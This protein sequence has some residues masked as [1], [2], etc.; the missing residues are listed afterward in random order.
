MPPLILVCVVFAD[1]ACHIPTNIT[2]GN[3][4]VSCTCVRCTG[5]QCMTCFITLIRVAIPISI[6]AISYIR[7]WYILQLNV[8][9]V[10]AGLAACLLHFA[11]YVYL[12]YY[13]IVSASPPRNVSASVLSFTEIQVSWTELPENGII[14]EYEVMYEPLMTFGELTILT[15]NTTNLSITLMDLQEY[16]QYNIS[17]RVYTSVGPGPY[18]ANIIRRT[19]EDGKP[20][21]GLQICTVDL[22]Y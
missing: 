20:T 1:F 8:W 9:Y 13:C 7:Q 12:M 15:V 16:V 18:S 4:C 19:F 14:T 11:V 21:V 17:V 2:F 6:L 5:T 10:A 22:A 3:V